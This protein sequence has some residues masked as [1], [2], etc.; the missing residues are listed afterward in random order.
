MLA[1]GTCLTRMFSFRV[2]AIIMK[3]ASVTTTA[4]SAAA[5]VVTY[6]PEWKCDST[7]SRFG[8]MSYF[9]RSG[10]PGNRAGLSIVRF[11]E[12]FL[13]FCVPFSLAQADEWHFQD[14]DRVV[15]FGDVH[16]AY[17]ALVTT[18]QNAE[19]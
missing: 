1:S 11:L 12:L 3:P 4:S 16:G 10:Q 2:P 7:I 8:S 18:L 14:I 17:D 9:Q 15:S 19:V 5:S 13:F 6:M